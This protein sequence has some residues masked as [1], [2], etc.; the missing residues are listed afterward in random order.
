[1]KITLRKIA[2]AGA[3]LAL[4]ACSKDFLT[5]VPSDFVA[6]EQFYKNSDD[7]V[8]AV[9]SVYASFINLQSPLTTSQYMG[10][11]LWMV[12][13]Y[14]TEVVTTRLSAANERTLVDD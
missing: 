5:E 8:A 12:L 11:N 13:E 7:A 10:R 3:L 14:P 6:P 4:P 9:N 1:M 2:L